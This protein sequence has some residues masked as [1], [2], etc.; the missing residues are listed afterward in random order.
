MS[1][2]S[3]LIS[4]ASC[5][6]ES[7]LPASFGKPVIDVEMPRGW[8]RTAAKCATAAWRRTLAAYVSPPL[9]AGVREAIVAYVARRWAELAA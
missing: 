1:A 5:W 8:S 6:L 9:A 7:G 4:H 3:H 2:E